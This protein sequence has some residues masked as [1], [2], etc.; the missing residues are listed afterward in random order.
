M[1]IEFLYFDGCPNYVEAKKV[2]ETLLK[3]E[4]VD[5]PIDVIHVRN[6]DEAREH[7]FLGSPSIRINDQD[8]E[9]DRRADLPLYGC[10]L[11]PSNTE[12]TGLPPSAMIIR[13][14]HSAR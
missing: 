8:I 9:V 3:K 6:E 4:D 7:G 12:N 5:D 11:Y 14:I 13:A 10:R 2:L 1:R